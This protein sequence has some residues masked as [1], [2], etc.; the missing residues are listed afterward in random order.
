MEEQK[1]LKEAA[2]ESAML[3]RKLWKER[4]KASEAK[5]LAGGVQFNEIPDKSGF[6]AAMKPVYE[7]FLKDNPNLKTL[8]ETIQNTP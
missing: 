2:V 6:Q 3:Q 5:V 4:E 8:V 7:K 1:I